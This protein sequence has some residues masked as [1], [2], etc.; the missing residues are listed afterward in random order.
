MSGGPPPCPLLRGPA[1]PQGS[2]GL[3]AVRIAW[4]VAV[5]F[6]LYAWPYVLDH[7][8]GTAG[9]AAAVLTVDEP[10]YLATAQAMVDG[11]PADWNPWTRERG[12]SWSP[13]VLVPGS[14][15]PMAGWMA[16]GGDVTLGLGLLSGAIVAAIVLAVLRLLRSLRSSTS[17]PDGTWVLAP[18]VALLPLNRFWSL[19]RAP[20]ADADSNALLPFIRPF[21]SQ[22][23]P[24]AFLLALV[25]LSSALSHGGG[26]RACLFALASVALFHTYPYG[27]PVLL[28]AA[29]LA[30]GLDPDRR[31]RASGL[32][33]VVLGGIVLLPSVALYLRSSPPQEGEV[34]SV[35]GGWDLV[36]KSGLALLALTT[37]H[38]AARVRRRQPGRLLLPAAAGVATALFLT[39]GAF[40]PVH[41]QLPVHV[42]YLHSVALALT[43][44]PAGA[45]V[46]ERGPR[47]VR[48]VLAVGFA[49]CCVAV[50]GHLTRSA[51]IRAQPTN[52]ANA[53]WARVVRGLTVTPATALLL[54][55]TTLNGPGGWAP[56][57]SRVPVL[58]SYDGEHAPTPSVD[59]RQ[60]RR[61]WYQWFL[62]RDPSGVEAYAKES[63]YAQKRIIGALVY[64]PTSAVVP[65]IARR[66]REIEA[67]AAEPVDWLRRYDE[68]VCVERDGEEI[69]PAARLERFLTA[70]ETRQAEGFR[71]RRWRW[72]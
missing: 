71:I 43:L 56:L 53:G 27:S 1:R 33:L 6:L 4:L 26:R 9:T 42:D 65:A 49:A 31:R 25:A 62:G 20:L 70:V 69:F 64:T 55:S 18:A 52:E 7:A 61:A 51:W 2:G 8:R 15:L 60:A 38:L 59:E 67:G 66:L 11:R 10:I 5:P 58:W 3:R 22:M 32:R 17:A 35:L 40:T 50:A 16:L 28:L 14:M 47:P 36:P 54:E 37:A 68:I 45:W 41:L 39:V 23:G 57:W 48:I 46:L 44:L 34:S 21:T 13:Y 30:A 72:K 24:A 12:R 19:G 63:V 29:G